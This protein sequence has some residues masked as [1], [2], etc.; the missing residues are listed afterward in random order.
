M[1]GVCGGGSV[2]GER[3][4]MCYLADV[5]SFTLHRFRKDPFLILSTDFEKTH[6]YGFTEQS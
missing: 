1:C 6:S 5:A 4:C 2:H 3:V